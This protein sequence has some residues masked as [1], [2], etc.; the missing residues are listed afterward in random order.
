M[1]L[2][3]AGLRRDL[4]PPS[5]PEPQLPSHRLSTICHQHSLTVPGIIILSP[6]YRCTTSSGTTSSRTPQCL[7][8][9]RST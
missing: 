3:S 8:C 1:S 6:A 5:V 7:M 4:T 9:A 2:I